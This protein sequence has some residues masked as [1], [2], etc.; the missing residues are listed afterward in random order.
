MIRHVILWKLKEDLTESEKKAA[1]QNIRNGLEALTDVIPGLK[2]I[3]VYTEG[4]ASSDCDLML[5]S[6]FED[7][8]ALDGYQAHPA[9]LNVKKNITEPAVSSRMLFDFE[10]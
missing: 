9:H 3:R 6:L 4:L 10:V 1:A 2:E 7:Q 8:A 5:D